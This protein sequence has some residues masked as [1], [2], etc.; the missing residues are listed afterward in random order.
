MALF[1]VGKKPEMPHKMNLEEDRKIGPPL[2]E[3][4]E[5]TF[6]TSEHMSGFSE[7][8]AGSRYAG[9]NRFLLLPILQ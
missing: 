5:E 9:P 7:A 8:L 6:S 2:A 1:K 3:S 4:E